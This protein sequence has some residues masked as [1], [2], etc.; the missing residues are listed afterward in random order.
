M[1]LK[2]TPATVRRIALPANGYE[3]WWGLV[4]RRA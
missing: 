3:L 4:Q 2:L 1:R